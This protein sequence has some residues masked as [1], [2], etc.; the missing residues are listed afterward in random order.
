MVVVADAQNVLLILFG[1]R[2]AVLKQ[3]AERAQLPA[4]NGESHRVE[5]VEDFVGSIGIARQGLTR[6]D[7]VVPGHIP[8]D[9]RPTRRRWCAGR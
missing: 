3:D 8:K 2:A 5:F 6:S 9:T 4:V 1:Q 7:L